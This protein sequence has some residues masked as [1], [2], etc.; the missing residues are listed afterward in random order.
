MLLWTSPI[1]R[2][3]RWRKHCSIG[4]ECC[5]TGCDRTLCN[6]DCPTGY[7][8]LRASGG[9]RVRAR[10]CSSPADGCR[11]EHSSRH[12][13]ATLEVSV[14]SCIKVLYVLLGNRHA[15]ILEGCQRLT[16]RKVGRMDR[17]LLCC[18]CGPPFTPWTIHGTVHGLHKWLET[19]P[20]HKM[21]STKYRPGNQYKNKFLPGC[22]KFQNRQWLESR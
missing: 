15:R 13:T 21:F 6:V 22:A 8:Q 17:C 3:N 4:G 11:G 2:L 19:I 18:T 16:C 9:D 7:P 1:I 12:R 5:V 14:L 10:V 20:S